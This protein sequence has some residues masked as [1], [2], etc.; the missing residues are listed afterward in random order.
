MTLTLLLKSGANKRN[1]IT[2]KPCVYIHD[3]TLF[4]ELGKDLDY[5]YKGE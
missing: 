1:C 5:W 3:V 4:T 2:Q